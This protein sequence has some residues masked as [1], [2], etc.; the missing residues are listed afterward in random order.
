MQ[1]SDLEDERSKRAV[2]SR[3]QSNRDL[4]SCACTRPIGKKKVA[5]GKTGC[6]VRRIL[7]R[8]HR[9]PGLVVR[10]NRPLPCVSPLESGRTGVEGGNGARR[11]RAGNGEAPPAAL[12]ES[13]REDGSGQ[14]K[15]CSPPPGHFEQRCSFPGSAPHSSSG[16]NPARIPKANPCRRARTREQALKPDGGRLIRINL[17]LA[18]AGLSLRLPVHKERHLHE[19]RQ[20]FLPEV[21]IEANQIRPEHLLKGHGVD[22]GILV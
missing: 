4:P 10:E 11:S 8:V 7:H 6:T 21:F 20:G 22:L 5:K 16:P 15:E 19:M 3:K 2:D 1:G 12:Q 14:G 17:P 13:E 9:G 18:S